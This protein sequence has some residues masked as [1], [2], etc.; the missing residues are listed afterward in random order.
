MTTH[1]YDFNPLHILPELSRQAL[2]AC[3]A[4]LM[5]LLCVPPQ[6]HATIATL[7]DSGLGNYA[8][9]ASPYNGNMNINQTTIK[10]TTGFFG[11][12]T[13]NNANNDKF[14][15]DVT[16]TSSSF[17]IN[18][19]NT[20][21]TGS[22]YQDTTING[23]VANAKN[24]SLAMDALTAT[25]TFSQRLSSGQLVSTGSV[26]VIDLLDG[27]SNTI[28]LK[29]SAKDI[30]Y[31]NVSNAFDITGI[32]L[33][34]VKSE[35]IYWNIV[36]AQNVNMSGD[37]AGTFLSLNGASMNINNAKISGAVYTNALN[38]M[39]QVTIT[40]FPADGGGATTMVPEASTYVAMAAFA[41][42][43]FGSTMRGWLARHAGALLRIRALRRMLRPVSA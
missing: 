35:N 10:G 5:F 19:P 18:G 39:N 11:F 42:L 2:L 1:K 25:Q 26:N 7:D 22:K 40:G 38:N 43:V 17:T 12:S 13:L 36:N 28:T 14:N 29:G 3:G 15:G 33:D 27:A 31:I 16:Y 4:A 32:K 23:V 30:F 8:L 37:L 21:V 41:L 6:A 24:F 9:V 20:T 34:G